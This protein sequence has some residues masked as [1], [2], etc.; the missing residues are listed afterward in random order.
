MA[1]RIENRL[2]SSF[3]HTKTMK[4][5]QFGFD[6]PFVRHSISQRFTANCFCVSL[7]FSCRTI[8]AIRISLNYF[9]F[10]FTSWKNEITYFS[11]FP[12]VVSQPKLTQFAS[13]ASKILTRRREDVIDESF[14][15]AVKR[16]CVFYVCVFLRR[17]ASPVKHFSGTP[18][19]DH[20]TP[21]ISARG[22]F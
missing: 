12:A 19:H 10:V 18:E 13:E 11:R 1:N 2:Y 5:Y 21:I 22:C 3:W 16:N 20:A 8:H 14:S 4:T 15:V 17:N 7:L 6:Y 9:K